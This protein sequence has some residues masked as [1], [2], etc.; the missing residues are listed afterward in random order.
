MQAALPA[1][2]PPRD[3]AV[4][5]F[6][7]RIAT[8]RAARRP[9]CLRGG[10]TKDFYGNEPAGDVLDTRAFHGTPA[11]EPT[12]LVVT[13]RCGTPLAEL[14]AL[15]A[16]EGQ[17]LPFEPPRYAPGGTVGGMVA[18]GLSG[19]PRASAGSVR[20]HV[21]GATLLDGHGTVL[22]FGGTVIKNVAG[23]DVSRLLA[24]S[25]GTLGLVLE[26][27]L[28][29]LPAPRATATLRFDFD[30]ATALSHLAAW[31][32]QALPLDASAWWD[33]N[34]VVRLRGA[35]A[36]VHAAVVRLGGEVI[37]AS[38]AGPFWNGL[39]DHTDDF[40]IRGRRVAERGGALWRLSLPQTA[41]PLALAGD[42]LIEW[43]GAQRW[44][45]ASLPAAEVRAATAAAG[46]YATLFRAG[47]KPGGTF[48]PLQPPLDRIHRELKRTFDPDGIF[49]PGRLYP[50]L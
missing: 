39:R 42:T 47:T 44:L 15:L 35:E 29:V 20:D 23:Y 38:A 46:G 1:A 28:K 11:Y 32:G 34:L 21:L 33:G 14:D 4:E 36:A 40:F 25:M 27:S 9:L 10:G 31:G 13:T 3:P 26:V 8:A 6:V 19:P 5:A 45:I 43:H 12:E 16:R 50:E 22:A 18:A 30:Q 37:D 49:N 7:E 41:P 24:G 2:A 48:A 17:C